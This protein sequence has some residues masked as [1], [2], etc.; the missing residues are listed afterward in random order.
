MPLVGNSSKKH[1]ND[2]SKSLDLSLSRQHQH[3][4]IEMTQLSNTGLRG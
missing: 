2:A 1:R 4:G 3:E